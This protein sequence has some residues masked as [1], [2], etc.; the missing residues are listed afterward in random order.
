[1]RYEFNL[2]A[3]NG[4]DRCW[5]FRLTIVRLPLDWLTRI[6][7]TGVTPSG[8]RRTATTRADASNALN[9]YWASSICP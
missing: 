5:N 6:T 4:E 7:E 3:L 9:H 8:L 1:M 2:P